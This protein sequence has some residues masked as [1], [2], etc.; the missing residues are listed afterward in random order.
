[1]EKIKNLS[2]NLAMLALLLI[3]GIGV[4][5]FLSSRPQN[6]ELAA[7][8]TD[9]KLTSTPVVEEATP[10]PTTEEK[11][12]LTPTSEPAEPED[13]QPE[14]TW[15]PAIIE[16]E[17]TPPPLPSPPPTPTSTPINPKEKT[18]VAFDILAGGPVVSPDDQ[19]L[20]I[21]AGLEILPE[22]GGRFLTQLWLVH[23]PNNQ[24]EKLDAYGVF[25]AWSPDGDQISF[26]A[27]QDDKFEITVINKD[28]SNKEVLTTVAEK[29]FLTYY[30]ANPD[31]IDIVKP[32]GVYK[33]DLVRKRT[34][35]V[36][37][38]V[39]DK[40]TGGTKPRVTGHPSEIIVV[41]EGRNLLVIRQNGQ[42]TTITDEKERSIG[43][44]VLSANGQKLAY[45]VNEGTSDELW[46]NNL[47]GSSPRMLYRIDRGHIHDLV[48]DPNN[49]AV[50]IGWRETGTSLSEDLT[51]LWIN[52]NNGQITPL[53]VDGVDRDF[54]FSH[55]GDR[56]FYSRTF[57][58]DP[59]DNGK[60][61]FYQLEIEQ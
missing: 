25:P 38:T 43:E 36:N 3:L 12:T 53:Q 1:M 8:V 27:R 48:W 9:T 2:G 16:P 11:A 54:V 15:T 10:T 32:D 19:T 30:W 47:T 17:G 21:V 13:D 55:K 41:G 28:G 14:P 37:L 49:Q 31:Q 58:A 46:T 7:Q 35:Q 40:T 18:I 56:L 6:N 5:L 60:T 52:V 22:Q 34:E 29:D 23:L 33:V 20:A 39:P 44:F 59:T 50:V 61:T 45:V 42:S 57:Y 4:M 51:L 26:M 24:V